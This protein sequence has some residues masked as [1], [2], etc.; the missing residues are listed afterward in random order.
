MSIFV[1][2]AAE[3][4]GTNLRVTVTATVTNFMRGAIT[5]L[6]P[7]RMWMENNFQFSLFQSLIAVGIVVFTMA[8]IAV[9]TFHETYGRKLDYI[10]E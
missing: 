5:L 10:E 4:F 2:T 1:T 7:L 3:S 6:I 8:F 9:S